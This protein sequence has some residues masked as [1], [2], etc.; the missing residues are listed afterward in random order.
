MFFKTSKNT[1][2][3]IPKLKPKIISLLFILI[4]SLK[5]INK[6]YTIWIR[7]Q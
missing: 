7:I 3:V 1:E 6:T 2:K 4:K 5:L